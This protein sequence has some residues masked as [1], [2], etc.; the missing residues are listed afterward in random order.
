M[1]SRLGSFFGTSEK[2]GMRRCPLLSKKLRYFS[3]MMLSPNFSMDRIN[4][5]RDLRLGYY[6]GGIF[7][8]QKNTPP[9]TRDEVQYYFA[10]PPFFPL[11]PRPGSGQL[12]RALTVPSAVPF[13]ARCSPAASYVSFLK[14][15]TV[16]LLSVKPADNYLSGSK[17][18]YFIVLS[19]DV[20]A[21][22][23]PSVRSGLY[24]F[25]RIFVN[26]GELTPCQAH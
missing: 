7:I 3:L 14:V 13:P 23:L 4:S 8:A 2:L 22:A 21:F 20:N 18:L 17:H 9:L 16:H 24:P 10:V 15:R 1:S 12:F 25:F 26:T 11:R 6:A 19:T 5:F